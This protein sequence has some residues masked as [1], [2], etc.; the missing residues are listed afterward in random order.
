MTTVYN[1][2]Y[3]NLETGVIKIDNVNFS[4][5]LLDGSYVP[6][7]AHKKS[8]VKGV[9]KTY[10]GLLRGTDIVTLTMS[11]IVDKIKNRMQ[12]LDEAYRDGADGFVVYDIG[13]QKLCFYEPFDRITDN[14]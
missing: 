12:D 10:P 14:G 9:I 11:E 13:T 1:D 4:V 2:Y 7:A 5:Q 8:A 6:D 3:A